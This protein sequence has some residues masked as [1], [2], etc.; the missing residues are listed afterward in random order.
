M[1]DQLRANGGVVPGG[2]ATYVIESPKANQGIYG[3]TPIIGTV[4]YNPD[5]IEYYRIDIGEGEVPTE[6]KTIGDIHNT[7][8]THGELEVLYAQGLQPG[9]YVLRLVLV[10]KDGNF[11]NPPFDIPIEVLSAP[12]TPTAQP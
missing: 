7:L 6:W 9:R 3:P 2:T 12:P 5:Q 10:Q 8:V 4:N 11:L 1:L